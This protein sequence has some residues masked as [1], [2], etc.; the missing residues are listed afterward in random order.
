MLHQF[1]KPSSPH[2]K[3]LRPFLLTYSTTSATTSSSS[4]IPFLSFSATEAPIPDST[5]IASSVKE[6]FK[7]SGTATTT[8]ATLSLMDQIYYHLAS[9]PDVASLDSSLSSLGL[10]LSEPLVLR[11]LSHRPSPS[12]V[13]AGS[14]LLLLRLKF[15][16][17]SGR[18]KPPLSP[19]RHTRSAYHA[20]FRLLSRARLASVVL[21]WLR[22]F[23]TAHASPSRHNPRFYDTLVIGYSV[24]GRP[25]LALQLLARMRFHGLDLHSFAYHVLL[26]SLIE[27]S[28]FDYADSLLDQ[29]SA[30]GLLTPV[31]DC[32]RIK[33]FC[34]QDRLDDAL[35]YLRL[36]QD[37]R[38]VADRTVATLVHA[39]CRRGRFDD[40]ERL[41]GEFRKNDEVYGAWVAGLISGG[42]L[43]KA[44]EF[45]QGRKGEEVYVPE[46]DMHYGKLISRLLNENRLEQVYDVLV[47]M[48]EEGFSPGKATMNAVLCFFCK[49]GMVDVA[50]Q[51]YHSRLELGISPTKWVYNYLISALC[52]SGNIE[53]VCEVLKESMQQGY[54]PGRKTFNILANALCR[55]G[56]IERLRKLLD[57]A[58]ER[59]IKPT[60]T[61]LARYISALCKAGELEAACLVPQVAGG[62]AIGLGR[63][64]YTYTSLIRAFTSLGRVEV[65]PR[66]IIEMQEHGHSPSR[67]LYRSVVCS[68]CEAERFE[69]VLHMLN[70]QMELKNIDPRMFYNYFIEGA[71]RAKKLEMAREI[72]SRME[73]A[74]V[75][76]NLDT[77]I[78]LL[79]GYLKSKMISNALSF[80]SYLHNERVPS[81]KL[82]SIFISGLCE[83][84][85]LD[86]AV[87]SWQEMREKRLIPSLQCYEEL[88]LTLCFWRKY[89]IVIDVL[90][91]FRNAGRKVSP[92]ICNVLLLH[93]LKTQELLETWYGRSKEARVEGEEEEGNR[94]TW[95]SSKKLLDQ[96]IAEFSHR[97][98]SRENLENL[99]EVVERYFPLD[100]YTY[101]ILMRGLSM[102]GQMDYAC[103]LF[104]KM[105][106]KGYEPNRWTYDV[107]VHGFCKQ[108]K[109][110]DAER[111]MEEMYRSGYH[112]TWYTIR[113]YNNTE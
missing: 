83:V 70:K 36:C 30:R 23:R 84:G 19:Y 107:L 28:L 81:T 61:V 8:T 48:I 104:N 11:A 1:L 52:R 66:L 101:N 56:D 110:K 59:D 98:R 39:L 18:L 43:D 27:S 42:R 32:I 88:V 24:A 37:S 76:P 85:K 12:A 90:E 74:G 108:G 58:V 79:M 72:Y 44:I 33:S 96:L 69:D 45:L 65:V 86:L 4:F 51:L 105:R 3:L 6:W 2:Y 10:R 82:Y 62:E 13:P 17:W 25:E 34:R 100:I 64:K 38:D 21:D 57:G 29:I 77:K 106:K 55:D 5:E 113:V 46:E 50:L 9:S 54:F 92:F 41:V 7:S 97:I 16:D 78:I 95:G 109:R 102:V 60:T 15:F 35:S 68:L 99:E 63:Y 111:W 73:S 22:S 47:E 80:F 93:T 75:Q 49:A 71:A 14:N 94:E 87:E 103:T 53:E 26:N 91:D 112:P 89:D 20:V 40:A 67:S 31:T